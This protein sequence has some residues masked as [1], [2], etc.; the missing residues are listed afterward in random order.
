[1]A[2]NRLDKKTMA[3]SLEGEAI[4]VEQYEPVHARGELTVLRFV[5]LEYHRFRVAKAPVEICLLTL[6]VKEEE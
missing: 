1:V 4:D 3:F 6:A 2:T 5:R